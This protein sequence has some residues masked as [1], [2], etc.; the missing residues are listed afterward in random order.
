MY[1][2]NV[3]VNLD[4]SIKEDW[5]RWM[6]QT[7]IPEVIAS[8]CFTSHRICKLMNVEDQGTTYA[9]QYFFNAL[10]DIDRYQKNYAPRLQKE[11]LAKF[12]ERAVAFR[13]MMEVVT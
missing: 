7:H 6:Q 13:T 1:I 8:G 12:G 10:E 5:I 3:T 11:H 4:D 2:Y 9:I